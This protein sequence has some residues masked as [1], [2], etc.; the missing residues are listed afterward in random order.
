MA[1]KGIVVKVG[2]CSCDESS[3]TVV[4][5]DL[6]HMLCIQNSQTLKS[7]TVNNSDI[8]KKIQSQTSS[9]NQQNIVHVRMNMCYLYCGHVVGHLSRKQ[10]EAMSSKFWKVVRRSKTGQQLLLQQQLKYSSKTW[11]QLASGFER[12]FLLMEAVC[13]M[14]FVISSVGWRFQGW[15]IPICIN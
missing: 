12:Q 14:L 8:L 3:V 6:I 4:W 10:E 1:T 2:S 13:L 11:T 9:K 15:G 7:V 5:G